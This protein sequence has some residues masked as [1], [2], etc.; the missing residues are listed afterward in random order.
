VLVALPLGRTVEF[1][2]NEV[3]EADGRVILD[4]DVEV[5]V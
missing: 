1:R 2:L 5:I 3:D 4:L